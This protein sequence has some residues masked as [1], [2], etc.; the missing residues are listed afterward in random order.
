MP[1]E[2]LSVKLDALDLN[3]VKS[4]LFQF[5][6][7]DGMHQVVTLNPEFIMAGRRDPELLAIYNQSDLTVADG[8]GLQFAARVL[9]VQIG[10]RVTGVD[11]SWELAKIASENGRSI[12]LLGAR[13]GVASM[14]AE[15]LLAGCPSLKIAGT[16]AGTPFEEGIVNRVND[17]GADILLVAFG[18]PKQ[19]KFIY[20]N[21]KELRVRVAMG[22]GGTFDYIAGVVPRA[23]IWMRAAGLEWLFRLVRQP[24]RLGRIF[25]AT[26]RF[27]LLVVASR[28]FGQSGSHEQLHGPSPD[29]RE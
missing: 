1:S 16:Y 3:G 11:L 17:S 13:D 7:A 25:T 15:K 20:R 2:I 9:G 27:P 4:R 18:S 12:F 21:R 19:E 29:F 24:Q 8:V 5:L 6:E 28:V 10:Q 22:V 26:V 14:A 23:P